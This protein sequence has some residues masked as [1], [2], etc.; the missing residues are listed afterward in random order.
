ML[1]NEFL[2]SNFN[3]P[4]TYIRSF[5]CNVAV[6]EFHE[7]LRIFDVCKMVEWAREWVSSNFGGCFVFKKIFSTSKVKYRLLHL[8]GDLEK[9]FVFRIANEM[10]FT[11]NVFGLCSKRDE[12]TCVH[13]D[14]KD[15]SIQ[16]TL[17]SITILRF[18]RSKLRTIQQT[19][20]GQCYR[21]SSCS[22]NEITITKI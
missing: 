4:P 3:V 11:S 20:Y 16:L 21:H 2:L 15:F 17:Q 19:A 8:E 14:C 6:V 9:N 12:I 13:L 1:A 5:D 7:N 10:N 18:N 22:L